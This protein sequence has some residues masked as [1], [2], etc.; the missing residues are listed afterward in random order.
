M[1][2]F[3]DYFVPAWIKGLQYYDLETYKHSLRVAKAFVSFTKYAGI[4]GPENL[5]HQS[6]MLHDIGKIAVSL[7]ILQ[8]AGELEE[9]ERLEVEKHPSVGHAWMSM[10]RCPE[11]TKMI[12][13]MHHER[14][15]GSGY[16]TGL[17]GEE[18]PSL[19]RMF[20]VIDVWDAM[21]N[22]RAYRGAIS[23]SDVIGYLCESSGSLFD[24]EAVAM[25]LSWR[26]LSGELP[27]FVS[28]PSAA[29]CGEGNISIT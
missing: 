8:K 9:Q 23:E 7:S 2:F 16:P 14:W 21:T 22:D 3:F 5:F 6:A 26:R 29:L 27:S 4:R 20:S 24:H 28:Y 25:F 15:D 12:L 13:L 19:V 18:T 17:R 10:L 1:T 11:E